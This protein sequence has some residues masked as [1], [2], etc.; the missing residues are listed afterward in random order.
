MLGEFGA[1]VEYLIATRGEGRFALKPGQVEFSNYYRRNVHCISGSMRVRRQCGAAA[2][3][4]PR[5]DFSR[6]SPKV[7]SQR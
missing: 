3:H 4:R 1:I 6:E 2:C 5:Y 7:R